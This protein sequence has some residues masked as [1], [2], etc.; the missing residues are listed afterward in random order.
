MEEANNTSAPTN[1]E[2]ARWSA[3]ARP[4]R[5]AKVPTGRPNAGGPFLLSGLTLV[6]ARTRTSLRRSRFLGGAALPPKGICVA[7]ERERERATAAER[8]SKRVNN[9]S[10][11]R[12][13]VE[14]WMWC[15]ESQA[16]DDYCMDGPK[17]GA[18]R[19]M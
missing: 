14:L 5:R 3:S 7:T 11:G 2:P 1:P 9:L 16:E 18:R 13:D 6:Q 12:V 4:R 17:L 10:V 15:G 8:D 19:T